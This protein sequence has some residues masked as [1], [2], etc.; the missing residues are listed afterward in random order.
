MVLSSHQLVALKKLYYSEKFM[1]G[2]DKLYEELKIRLP[3]NFPSKN[4][5]NAWL[6]TQRVAQLYQIPLKPKIV[7]AFRSIRPIHSFSIDLIDYSNKPVQNHHYVVNMIDNFSRFMWTIAIKNKKPED[8]VAAITPIFDKLKEKYKILPKYI[9][10]DA[11]GEFKGAYTKYLENVGI[12]RHRTIGGTPSSNGMVERSNL[13]LKV[14]MARIKKVKTSET[15]NIYPNWFTV[16]DES[17]K[18][19]NNSYHS[20]IKMKPID[21]I[22]LTDTSVIDDMTNRQKKDRKIHGLQP[23]NHKVGDKVRL[24]ILKNS[25]SKYSDPNWSKE[26]YDIEKV[27]PSRATVATKY[28]LKGVP[29]KSWTRQHIQIVLGDEF[30]EEYA[31]QTRAAKKKLEAPRRSSRIAEPK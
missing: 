28:V 22:E 4:N 8:V 5:I 19:Y 12:R 21:A 17:T 7:T 29:G 24:R 26:I 23:I 16:L 2:R 15:K 6:K 3:A 27:R 14:I 13:T 9:L 30:P 10:S 20:S 11:G 1:V 31:I 18:V 25:L